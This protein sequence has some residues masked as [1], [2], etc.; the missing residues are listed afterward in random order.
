MCKQQ[1]GFE[2]IVSKLANGGW[3]LYK[4][5]KKSEF[6]RKSLSEKGMVLQ[7]N[8]SRVMNMIKKQH[9]LAK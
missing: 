1:Q 5:H 3:L 8:P 4:C 6:I 7:K 9:D 2:E